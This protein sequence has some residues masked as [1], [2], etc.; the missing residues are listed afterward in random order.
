MAQVSAFVHFL[1]AFQQLLD[2][3]AF[4]NR[5]LPQFGGLSGKTSVLE[6]WMFCV[7]NFDWLNYIVGIKLCV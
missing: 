3:F 2:S 6:V 5:G 7:W 4:W 1:K